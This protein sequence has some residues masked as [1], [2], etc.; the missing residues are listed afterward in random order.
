MRFF[1]NVFVGL[2]AYAKA[3]RFMKQ[4]KLYWFMLIP[5]ALML[6]IYA[7]GASVKNHHVATEAETVN[8]IIWL[9]IYLLAEI[10]VALLLM[11][12]SKYLVVA[13]LSPLLAHLSEKTEKKLTGNTYPWD[14]K[15][16]VSDVKRAMRIVVRNLMWEYCFFLVL[17][18][19]SWFGWEDPKSSPVFYL[20]YAIGFYYYGFSFIDYINERRRLSMDEGI[21]FVR[22]NR[23]LA[24]TIGAGYSLLILVPVDLEAMF[25]FSTFSTDFMGTL[26]TIG[27]NL[28]LWLCASAAPILAIIA[29]TIAMNDLVDLSTNPYAKN[30]CP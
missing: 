10:S 27:L 21:V 1:K 24:I 9:G 22:K 29:A 4:H 2:R 25:N 17:L 19:V 11:K 14:F 26:G 30:N 7:I 8:D 23:G 20:T 16:L 12:F 18:L 3:I 15:Q 13:I 28:V 6:M 5:A